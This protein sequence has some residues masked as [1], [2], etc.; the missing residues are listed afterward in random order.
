MATLVWLGEGGD[1]GGASPCIPACE[2]QPREALPISAALTFDPGR[3]GRGSGAV[4][5]SGSV[6]RGRTY[7]GR[8]RRRQRVG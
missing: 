3:A 1:G 4:G 5:L 7:S 8:G 6:R 2:N